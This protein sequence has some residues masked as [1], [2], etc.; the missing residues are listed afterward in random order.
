MRMRNQEFGITPFFQGVNP[1]FQRSDGGKGKAREADFEAAF[2]HA[3][4]SLNLTSES[5]ARIV[6]LGDNTTS[7]ENSDAKTSS[8]NAEYVLP[9]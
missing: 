8:D 7:Q 5:S 1:T 6:E 3:M 4:E 9:I 2:A